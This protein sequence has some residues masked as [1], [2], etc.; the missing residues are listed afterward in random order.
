MQPLS[1][2]ARSPPR[3]CCA[4]LKPANPV[5]RTPCLRLTLSP[6]GTLTACA[7]CSKRTRALFRSRKNST[8]I[9]WRCRRQSCRRARSISICLAITKSG[10]TPSVKAI[11]ALR[12]LAARNR[13]ACCTPTRCYPTPARARRPS[14]SPK[15]QPRAASVRSSSTSFGLWM[16][17]RPTRKTNSPAST[18][19]WPGTMPT[20]TF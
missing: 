20:A 5:E 10:A 18:C 4:N 9:S 8:S 12:S 7:P 3:P 2:H 11:R 15:P 1:Q 13:C 6:R 14:S 17:T 16:S 19:A